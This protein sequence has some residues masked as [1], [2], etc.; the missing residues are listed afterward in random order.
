MHLE[1]FN[2]QHAKE[3][4]QSVI[5]ELNNP[6]LFIK[7]DFNQLRYQKT[8]IY[9]VMSPSVCLSKSITTFT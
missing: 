8:Y 6:Q 3:L 5:R 2:S 4:Q 9:G 1:P 7:M